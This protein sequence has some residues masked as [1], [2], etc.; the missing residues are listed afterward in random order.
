[1]RRR[2]FITLIGGA[3]AAWPTH[4]CAEHAAQ[5][6]RVGVLMN[7][8]DGD[9]ETQIRITAF[10]Q[11]MEQA[12]WTQGRN[13]LIEYRW[14]IGEVERAR[15]AASE[16]LKLGPDV[17]LSNATPATAVLQQTTSTIPDP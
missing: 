3:A 4:V 14:S 6:R 5:M 16:L 7:T 12:G 2:E 8:A 1:M 13:V 11:A 15:T 9:P 10:Q 17:I